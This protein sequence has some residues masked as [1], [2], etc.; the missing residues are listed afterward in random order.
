MAATGLSVAANA[1]APIG[2]ADVA[3][4]AG[5]DLYDKL[6]KFRNAPKEVDNLLDIVK[7]LDTAIASVKIYLTEFGVSQYV[8]QDHQP[9]PDTDEILQGCASEFTK[10]NVALGAAEV[11]PSDGWTL[12]W[13]KKARFVLSEE[14]VVKSQRILDSYINAL[15]PI[16][17]IHQGYVFNR[18]VQCH[19]RLL[20]VRQAEPN[21]T[22]TR[23]TGNTD[24]CQSW[25]ERYH[26]SNHIFRG[27]NAATCRNFLPCHRGCCNMHGTDHTTCDPI[28][29]KSGFSKCSQFC[30][31]Y[32]TGYSHSLR[33]NQQ[34]IIR[35]T[36]RS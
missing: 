9:L 10:L 19:G 30:W 5:K 20:D 21:R 29:H 14:E 2:L 17:A 27:Y 33:N 8:T 35:R 24:R 7:R 15:N 3:F 11:T 4:R 36:A 32:P 26:S 25:P 31:R 12:Q 18:A 23:T 34:G 16:L 28:I 1:F 22:S 6:T 13:M